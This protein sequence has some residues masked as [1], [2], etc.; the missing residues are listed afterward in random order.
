MSNNGEY[1]IMKKE[2]PFGVAEM[3]FRGAFERESIA[4]YDTGLIY[5]RDIPEKDVRAALVFSDR[6]NIL[7]QPKF[8]DRDMATHVEVPEGECYRVTGKAP[9]KN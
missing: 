8:T 9:T 7:S 4:I 1:F 6:L 2:S 3:T 5:S